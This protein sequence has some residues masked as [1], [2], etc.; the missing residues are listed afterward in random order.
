MNKINRMLKGIFIID[1]KE[2]VSFIKDL[3]RTKIYK[4]GNR[5]G[6][7]KTKLIADK[8]HKKLNQRVKE[9]LNPEN[10]MNDEDFEK[11]LNDRGN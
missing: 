7:R 1:N 8:Y 10:W 11:L 6:K 3:C 9:C 2:Y 4:D 5:L